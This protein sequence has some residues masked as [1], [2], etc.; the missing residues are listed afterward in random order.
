M[1]E[2]KR[3]SL[4][5]LWQEVPDTEGLWW[6]VNPEV[7]HQWLIARVVQEPAKMNP[8]LRIH[9]AGERRDYPLEHFRG[10]LVWQKALMP[11]FYWPGPDYSH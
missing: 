1:S 4:N 6:A 7:P 5:D 9:F 2:V 11:I 8:R 3:S 10:K